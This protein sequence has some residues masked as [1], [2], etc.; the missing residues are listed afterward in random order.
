MK[1]LRPGHAATEDDIAELCG[2]L[3][4]FGMWNGEPPETYEE[5]SALQDAVENFQASAG[6]NVDGWVGKNTRAALIADT[7]KKGMGDNALQRAMYCMTGNYQR[8][9]AIS[10]L[11]TFYALGKRE[12]PMG[13]N[14]V[15]WLPDVPSWGIGE[16]WCSYFVHDGIKA[17]L[18][19][20]V[21]GGR[22]GSCRMD[23]KLAGERG[24]IL[25]R[26]GGGPL[27]GDIFDVFGKNGVPRHTGMVFHIDPDGAHCY[28]IEGN[29]NNRVACVK[30][31]IQGLA[32]WSPF[33]ET[34]E[35]RAEI[36]ALYVPQALDVKSAKGASDR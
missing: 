22:R 6:L 9:D 13:S 29:Y 17:G 4:R 8:A 26:I 15:P 24:M 2:Q 27:P 10:R 31:A 32:F 25:A 18:G 14:M 11:H 34:V 16:P 21:F 28:T 1:Y 30:R 5:G 20:Y 36:R 7:P 23:W 12:E 35:Q 33:G 3:K 19:E